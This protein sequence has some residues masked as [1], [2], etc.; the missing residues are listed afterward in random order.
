[1]NPDIFV[2][3]EVVVVSGEDFSELGTVAVTKTNQDNDYARD[4]RGYLKIYGDDVLLWEDSSISSSTK[5][6]EMS[7]DI[8][9]VTDLRIEI[10]GFPVNLMYD[11][12]AVIFDDVVLC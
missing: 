12:L 2:C 5:P 8:S 10:C 9:G 3:P 11:C 7:V 6:Y 1:M 4:K